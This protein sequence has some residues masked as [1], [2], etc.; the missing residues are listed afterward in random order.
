ML[1]Q[2]KFLNFNILRSTVFELCKIRTSA[3]PHTHTDVIHTQ[4]KCRNLSKWVQ[5]R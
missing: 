2:S 1:G 4:T 3:Y 5:G